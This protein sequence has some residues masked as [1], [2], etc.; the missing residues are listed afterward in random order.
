[1]KNQLDSAFKKT[2][3]NWDSNPLIRIE[4]VKGKEHICIS[5]LD[6]LEEPD[7]LVLLR[8]RV[9]A[10]MPNIDLPE[11]LLEIAMLTGFVDQFTHISQ[12]SSRMKDLHISI[13]AVLIAK[14]C[15]IGFG[16]LVHLGIEA[17]EYDRLTWVEQNYFRTETLL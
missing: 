2:A 9:N 4:V 8:K 1:M 17:L 15:N 10:L 7:S 16:P 12:G 11:L 6:K 14:A 13:C 5:P 3:K